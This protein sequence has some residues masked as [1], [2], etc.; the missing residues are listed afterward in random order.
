MRRR[1][2]RANSADDNCNPPHPRRNASKVDTGSAG[3]VLRGCKRKRLCQHRRRHLRTPNRRHSGIAH[4]HI[5]GQRRGSRHVARVAEEHA[6]CGDVGEFGV[7]DGGRRVDVAIRQPAAH[8][9]GGYALGDATLLDG[10]LVA[11]CEGC[12][13]G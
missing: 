7:G 5:P 1:S 4:R 3:G 8:N 13:L 11:G 2:A 9:G 10:E 12:G 6:A